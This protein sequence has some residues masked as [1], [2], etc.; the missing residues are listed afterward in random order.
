MSLA[1]ATADGRVSVRCQPAGL[2][3]VAGAA[4]RALHPTCRLPA[5]GRTHACAQRSCHMCPHPTAH[6]P[7]GEQ[8]RYVLLKGYDERGFVFY[9]NYDSSKGRQLEENQA[10]ALAFWWEPLQ[11]QVRGR[12]AA[13][14]P[15]A[16]PCLPPWPAVV[17]LGSWPT[18]LLPH[19]D[20][21]RT[22]VRIEGV[23]ERVPEAES[24]A[25]FYS[26]P[27][28]VGGRVAGWMDGLVAG[29]GGFKGAGD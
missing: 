21:R 15:A 6:P 2:G 26:R 22:Q 17:P 28:W 11:R 4:G 24:D 25:Y 16:V 7:T 10:A 20:C 5:A 8:A 27:R 3:W 13:A 29:A 18:P 1:T 9:T 12:L 23:V 14:C 19:A